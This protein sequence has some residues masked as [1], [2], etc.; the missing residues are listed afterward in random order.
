MNTRQQDFCKHY[1]I[2]NNASESYKLAGY[3]S[4]NA[5]SVGT[6]SHSLL[7]KPTIQAE[8][9]RL[10]KEIN[11]DLDV[12][13]AYIT[14]KLKAI[15]E[16]VSATNSDK[17]RALDLLGSNLGYKQVESQTLA[18]FGTDLIKTLTT[19]ARDSLL[20]SKSIDITP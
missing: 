7:H 16:D 6:C 19:K 17:I 8:I 18:L 10:S 13:C 11:Q 3:K 1:I 2:T 12:D 9:T 4:K 20:I 5:N 14:R 15:A